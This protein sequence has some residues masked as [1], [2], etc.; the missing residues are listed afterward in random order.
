MNLLSSLP[1]FF[2]ILISKFIFSSSFISF[3][4]KYVKSI[5]LLFGISNNFLISFLISNSCKFNNNGL[6]LFIFS[7]INI[8]DI[9]TISLYISTLSNFIIFSLKYKKVSVKFTEDVA[10]FII[11]LFLALFLEK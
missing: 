2:K 8:K 9:S 11:F 6:H 4:I 3:F 5:R 7:D 1:I 10:I